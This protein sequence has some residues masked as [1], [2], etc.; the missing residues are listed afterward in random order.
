MLCTRLTNAHFLTM[1]PDHPVARE[2]GVARPDRRPGR[3]R[4]RPARARGDRPPGRHRPP[5]VIDAHV[6]LP[7]TGFRQNTPSIAGLTRVDDVLAAVERAVTRKNEPGSWVSIA[8]YDQR[9]LGRRL[10]AAEPDRVCHGHKTVRPARLRPRLRRRHRRPGPAPRRRPA[11]ERLP[12]RSRDGRRPRPAAA[13][14]PGGAGRDHRPAPPA[15]AWT[16]ASPPAPKRASAAPSSA[17]APSS[18]APT[19]S[20][21]TRGCCRCACS[22]WSPRTGCARSPHTPPTASPGP[23]TWACAPDPATR[24]SPSVH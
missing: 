6:H 9:A 13:L 3:R 7:W 2:L 11:R 24:T 5:R 15:P 4:D 16:R 8:G 1:D 12:R 23:S 21:A 18:W 22:S 17:T 19:N 10:T 14:L 20:P